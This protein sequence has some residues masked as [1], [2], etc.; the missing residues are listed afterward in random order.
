MTIYADLTVTDDYIIPVTGWTNTGITTPIPY[1]GSTSEILANSIAAADALVSRNT[2]ILSSGASS[3]DSYY[4]GYI[5]KLSRVNLTTG[6][7]RSQEKLISAYV[8]STKVA[9]IDDIW[10]SDF[11]PT[12]G[13]DIQI[14]PPFRDKRASINPAII[15]LDYMTATTYGKGLDIKNDLGLDSWL[16]TARVC[17]SRSNVTIK[18]STAAT[19]TLGSIYRYPA[20]GDILWQ[21]KLDSINGLY[22]TFTDV[23]GKFTNKWNNWKTFPI[24]ALVYNNS[25]L[26]KITSA[27]VK[28]AEPVHTS[29]SV[30]GLDVVSSLSMA[31]TGQPTLSIVVG[32]NPVRS[33]RNGLEIPGYSLYDADGVDYF[34]LIGWHSHD[35]RWATKYQVN[36]TIDTSIPLFE[37]VNSL[38]EHFNG[39]LRY[40]GNKYNLDIEQTSDIISSSDPRNITNDHII[41]KIRLT[42][43]GSSKSYN[44]LTAS[45]PDPANKF[46]SRNISFFN[47][48]YLK[49]DKNLPKKGN[50]SIPGISNY[51]NTRMLADSYLNKSRYGLSIAFNMVPSGLLLLPGQVIQLQYPRY[52]WVDKKFR[53]SSLTHQTDATVDIIAEEYDDS[54]YSISNV[55][56][57]DGSGP[58]GTPK[59]T[60]ISNPTDLH[61]TDVDSGDESFSIIELTW[62]NSPSFNSTKNIYTEIYRGSSSLLYITVSSI[63]SNVFTT[64]VAHQLQIGDIITPTTS[65]GGLINKQYFVRTVP[66]STTFTLSETLGGTIFGIA[67]ASGLSLSILTA[68]LI[69]TVALPINKYSDSFAGINGRVQKFYWVRYKV[70]GNS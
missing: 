61:A 65:S 38:L 17:D 13:D 35:Q 20:T 15:T 54:F 3:T 55:S 9:T 44:S 19:P 23:I 62:T 39:I 30:N 18:L 64:T 25:V 2:I 48:N 50:L 22:L 7:V 46:E 42:D 26:Y 21:G 29:G 59:A 56:K 49:E 69:D 43:T 70:V 8:G 41:D 31:L 58:S 12:P 63:T 16:A 60:A 57:S 14:Y 68:T 11:T 51:Y 34:R 28:T 5:I 36:V 47:S 6:K 67:N 24:D 40:T 1:N 45:Y 32:G 27:G 53:I 10:E 66:S 4:V 37:N 52:G 33:I